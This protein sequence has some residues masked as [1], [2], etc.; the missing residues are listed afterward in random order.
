V[1]KWG[2]GW[3]PLTNDYDALA[4]GR[5]R[6]NEL[7]TEAGRDPKSISISQMATEGLSRTVPERIEAERAGADE[8]IVWIM[9]TELD[10]VLDELK[11]LA[12][13][14]IVPQAT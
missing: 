12:D 7:C 1:A 6:L 14:L 8:V 2:D 4:K 5:E 11:T 10:A 9:A 3:V 13:E